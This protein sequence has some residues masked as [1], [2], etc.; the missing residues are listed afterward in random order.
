MLSLFIVSLPN[1]EARDPGA[2]DGQSGP[3]PKL[4]RG[5]PKV[6]EGFVLCWSL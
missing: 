4:G 6:P 1:D 2:R 5:V 3:L